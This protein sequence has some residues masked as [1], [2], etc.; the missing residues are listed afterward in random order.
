M[1]LFETPEAS[2]DALEWMVGRAEDLLRRLGLAYRVLL[3]ATRDMGFVQA[4]KYDLEV[5]APGVERWLE[6]S[7]CSNFRD[8]QARRM[9]IRYRPAPGARPELAHTLNGSGLALPRVVAAILETYQ[10]PD[11]SVRVPKPLQAFARDGGPAPSS[12][13]GRRRGSRAGETE[14]DDQQQPKPGT[15]PGNDA[16]AETVSQPPSWWVS[17]P[18][19]PGPV[20]GRAFGSFVARL[21]ACLADMFFVAVAVVGIDLVGGSLATSIDL[22]GARD[23]AYAM[24]L[25]TMLAMLLVG[26]GYFP[27]SWAHGGQTP[28]MR[29]LGLRVIRDRDGGPVSAGAAMLRLI[30]CGIAGVPVG[31]GYAWIL[32]DGRRRGWHDLFAG[33]CVISTR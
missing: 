27:W 24:Y 31:L 23:A 20:P 32:V 12:L 28:G 25:L 8:Y 29:R 10:G 14:T 30:G 17:P 3:M 1:V 16:G 11:G 7:S 9:A 26:F 33:T 21:V 5:W 4:K 13:K 18:G 2:A 22:A 6:V 19:E 15:G